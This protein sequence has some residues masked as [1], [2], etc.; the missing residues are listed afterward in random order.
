M[1]LLHNKFV[2]YRT[3]PLLLSLPAFLFRRRGGGR[4]S[5]ERVRQDGFLRAAEAQDEAPL[6]LR[7]LYRCGWLQVLLHVRLP[8]QVRRAVSGG[9]LR[10]TLLL[11][12][13]L[14][15]WKFLDF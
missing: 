11:A 8:R 7:W 10:R 13:P 14:S 1:D 12:L 3:V 9:K 4:A 2:V 6:R 5:P 15:L